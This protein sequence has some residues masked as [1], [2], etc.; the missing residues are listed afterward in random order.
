MEPETS[1]VPR[2]RLEREDLG[3]RGSLAG[4]GQRVL[5]WVFGGAGLSI[6]GASGLWIL[7]QD[8]SEDRLSESL[9]LVGF[10]AAGY[11]LG[12]GLLSMVFGF[13]HARALW[14]RAQDEGSA[15]L[16]F[17]ALPEWLELFI[18]IFLVEVWRRQRYFGAVELVEPR[19]ASEGVSA[20]AYL[21][22][23]SKGED[24]QALPQIAAW[25]LRRIVESETTT[26]KSRTKRRVYRRLSLWAEDYA[27]SSST[28]LSRAEEGRV[29]PLS[30]PMEPP[31][32][33]EAAVVSYWELE[34]RAEGGRPSLR[35]VLS[36]SSRSGP[37]SQTRASES[38][39]NSCLR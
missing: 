21:L 31:A 10:V 14:A 9:R 28:E 39:E 23:R 12:I 13:R 34:L 30:F 32:S 27:A 36:V 37:Q 11:L 29:L 4:E 33:P 1:T 20:S 7:I 24:L 19:A 22:R 38:S 18:P 17:V 8:L 6:L 26:G 15:V 35:F 2:A 5:A 16:P 3:T 25:T